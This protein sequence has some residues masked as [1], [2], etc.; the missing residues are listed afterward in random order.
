VVIAPEYSEAALQVFAAKPNVRV[1]IVPL[2]NAHNQYD[3][4]RV[5]GGLLVQTPDI[6]NG[7]GWPAQGRDT[8]AT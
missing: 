1:L 7:A 5:G 4:K 8:R 2:S 6:L 3:F